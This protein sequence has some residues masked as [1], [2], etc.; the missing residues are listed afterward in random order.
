MRFQFCFL[1][2]FTVAA[3]LLSLAPSGFSTIIQSSNRIDW[4]PGVTVGS[5][6]PPVVRT[7]IVNVTCDKTG[8]SD[9]SV[10]INAAIQAANPGDVVFLSNGW[11]RCNQPIFLN[12][13]NVTLRGESTNAIIFSGSSNYLMTMGGQDPLTGE[14]QNSITAGYQKGS[15]TLTL[16]SVVGYTVG[17]IVRIRHY[18]PSGRRITR[19]SCPRL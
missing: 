15:T 3:F 8:V 9:C 18:E 5:R 4:I 16:S 7:R 17:D 10:A 11:Y 14:A 12:K 13:D 19:H 1:K 2:F 6:V